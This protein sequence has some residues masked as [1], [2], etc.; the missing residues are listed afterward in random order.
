MLRAFDEMLGDALMV[1][2]EKTGIKIVKHSKVRTIFC[3]T[4]HV[5]IWDIMT[6]NDNNGGRG[7]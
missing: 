2:M 6:N 5:Y 3:F 4:V 7:S 1:E